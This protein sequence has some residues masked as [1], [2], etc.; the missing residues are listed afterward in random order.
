MKCSIEGC[1]GEY[2]IKSVVHTVRHRGQVV[3]VDHVPAEVCSTC[4]DVLFA[5][6]TVR[7]IEHVL[8]ESSAPSSAPSR[9]VPLYEFA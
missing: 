4:G 8:R 5:P 6:D 7:R 1:P 2:E 9:S 3:V